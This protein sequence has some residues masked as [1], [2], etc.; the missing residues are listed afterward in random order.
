M[1]LADQIK[2]ATMFAAPP[3]GA[4]NVRLGPHI[5]GPGGKW[6]P[7]AV[8]IAPG[9]YVSGVF[10]IGPGRRQVCATDRFTGCADEALAWAV[11]LAETAAA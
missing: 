8:A 10:Q 2:P 3:A 7:C 1:K 11:E 9:T 5:E 6:I 4:R